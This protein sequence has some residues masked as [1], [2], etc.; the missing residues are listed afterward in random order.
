[1]A[2]IEGHH[3]RA[4]WSSV[5]GFGL[6][7]GAGPLSMEKMVTGG[8]EGLGLHLGSSRLRGMTLSKVIRLDS[9]SSS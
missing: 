8:E 3:W 4:S 5:L 1:M 9:I 7:A 6:S 2:P